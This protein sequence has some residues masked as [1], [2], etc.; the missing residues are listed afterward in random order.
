MEMPFSAPM[1]LKFRGKGYS[2]ALPIGE[3]SHYIQIDKNYLMNG[4]NFVAD[5]GSIDELTVEVVDKT[6]ALGY[7]NDFVLD[8]FL[9]KWVVTGGNAEIVLLNY[10]ARVC[11]PMWI[12][13]TYKNNSSAAKNMSVN[14]H[15]HEPTRYPFTIM[16]VLSDS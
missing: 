9:D 15:L 13:I 10:A 3:S 5:G 1:G 12:K 16:D 14:L 6:N 8:K 11:P 7:G 2:F 4:G